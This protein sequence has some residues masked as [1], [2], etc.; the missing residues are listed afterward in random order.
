MAYVLISFLLPL[1]VAAM[2]PEGSGSCSSSSSGALLQNSMTH[3]IGMDDANKGS[4]EPLLLMLQH[5]GAQ[6]GGRDGHSFE[7]LSSESE[8]LLGQLQTRV[9]SAVLDDKR[10][11]PL[12]K[13]LMQALYETFENTTLPALTKG[14]ED[15]QALM[16]RTVGALA[17]CNSNFA[18]D[19]ESADAAKKAVDDKKGTHQSCRV[20]EAELN[21]THSEKSKD[22]KAVSR[23]FCW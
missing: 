8:N 19:S 10:L 3:Q 16:N 15:D 22:L 18:T 17:D 20:T 23:L 6:Q 21:S 12:E 11:S 5:A 13:S 14:H 7:D 4:L 9:E 2:C 1:V